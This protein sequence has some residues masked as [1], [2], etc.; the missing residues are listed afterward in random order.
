[1]EKEQFIYMC[2]VKNIHTGSCYVK[3]GYTS[4]ILKRMDQLEKRNIHYEYSHFRLFKHDVKSIGYIHDEQKIHNA[5]IKY[6]VAVKRDSMPEGYTECYEYGFTDVLVR[7]LSKL[8]YKCV[9]DH[10]VYQQ[11]KVQPMFEWV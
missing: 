9:F 6:R 10:E 3:L 11:E 2:N 5:N 7:Q 4:D 8:N 1:M